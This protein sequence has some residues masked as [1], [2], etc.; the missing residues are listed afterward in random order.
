MR[1]L[2]IFVDE[3]GDFGEYAKHSP[4]YL[5]GMIFHDQSEQINDLVY[6]LNDN[7]QMMGFSRDFYI[8]T[9][10]AI[11]REGEFS[12]IGLKSRKILV[13]RLFSFL[14]NAPV[15]YEVFQIEKKHIKDSVDAVDK[16][17]KQIAEFIQGNLE[18]F[19]KYDQIKIYYDNGQAEVTKIILSVFNSLL[20]NV[21]VRKAIPSDYKLFQ[22]ADL[23]CTFRLLHLKYDNKT[24]SKSELTFFGTERRLKKNF[25]VPLSKKRFSGK[26]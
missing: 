6:H 25:L 18:V 4:Y 10:Q 24:L 7:L 14:R 15:T 12:R 9:S 26:L 23:A 11:R 2:S 3:S 22:A 17:S 19:T 8:H 20:V 1:E 16:L 21:D 13:A 5:I